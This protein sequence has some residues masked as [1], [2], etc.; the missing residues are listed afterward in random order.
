[1]SVTTKALTGRIRDAVRL[2]ADQGS[3]LSRIRPPFLSRA[4]PDRITALL[5]FAINDGC[6]FRDGS[7]GTRVTPIHR[8]AALEEHAVGHDNGQSEP[9]PHLRQHAPEWPGHDTPLPAHPC[10]VSFAEG[11]MLYHRCSCALHGAI[12][13]VQHDWRRASSDWG[14]GHAPLSH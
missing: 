4:N 14:D 2:P 12:S 11:N 1:M 3:R 8:E 6:Q 9:T 10:G 13:G 7:H 5:D